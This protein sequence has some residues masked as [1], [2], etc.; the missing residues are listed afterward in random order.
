MAA[1]TACDSAVGLTEDPGGANAEN[2]SGAESFLIGICP[3]YWAHIPMTISQVQGLKLV[4]GINCAVVPTGPQNNSKPVP[5]SKC[6][7]VGYII[8]AEM[9]SNGSMSYVLD[10]GTGLVDC[11][12]WKTEDDIYYLPSL[13]DSQTTFKFK[14]GDL[15]RIFG[16]IQ[17]ISIST[18]KQFMVV[19]QRKLVFRDCIR[20]IQITAI[21]HVESKS[22]QNITLDAEAHH[23]TACGNSVLSATGPRLKNAADFLQILGSE[24]QHQVEDRRNLPAADDT[25][26]AWRV[27]GASCRCCLEYKDSLLYCHCQAKIEPL[28]PEFTFRDALV[29]VLL[30]MQRKH[31][32]KL[33]FNYKEVAGNKILQEIAIKQVAGTAKPRINF[34]RLFLNT[35]RALRNDGIIFL[36]NSG[37]DMYLLVSRDRVLEPYVRDDIERSRANDTPVSRHFVNFDAAPFLSKVHHERLLYI[38]RCLSQTNE[39]RNRSD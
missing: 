17:C 3:H 20:E 12:D 15:V 33:S 19:A 10:D 5:L 13:L 27:F 38:R 22:S 6:L 25:L 7:L 1:V 23:W 29:V 2:F 35:F 16:K 30:E 34:D 9:R 37:T 28:D 24:I 11:V 8:N 18:E 31:E 4:D 14:I 26:A 36:T 32:K 21:E 39:N